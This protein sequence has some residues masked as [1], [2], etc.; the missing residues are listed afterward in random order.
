MVVVVVAAAPVMM[1]VVEENVNG[2]K[3]MEEMEERES[4]SRF[5]MK[6]NGWLRFVFW[7]SQKNWFV[8]EQTT[9]HITLS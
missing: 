5:Q 4:R 8:N 7:F 1:V 6:Q 3:G 9:V 2:R